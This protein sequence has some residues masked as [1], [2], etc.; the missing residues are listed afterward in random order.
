MAWRADGGFGPRCRRFSAANSKRHGLD[1]PV[2]VAE[3]L[4]L[5]SVAGGN[6]CY[7]ILLEK[8]AAELRWPWNR[9]M[10]AVRNGEHDVMRLRPV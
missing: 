6:N 2:E 10:A 8:L 4:F 7:P 1:F 3:Q 5:G 9:E